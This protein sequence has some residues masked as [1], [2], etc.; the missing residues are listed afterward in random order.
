MLSDQ[1]RTHQLM[2]E[3]GKS[4]LENNRPESSVQPSTK[5]AGPEPSHY[6]HT[7]MG[8]GVGLFAPPNSDTAGQSGLSDLSSSLAWGVGVVGPSPPN[9]QHA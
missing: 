3:N 6:H 2:L 4:Q 5:P 1:W 7:R 9:T 8:E